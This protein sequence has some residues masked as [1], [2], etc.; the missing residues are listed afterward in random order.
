MIKNAT[1]KNTEFTPNLA[2]THPRK[3]FFAYISRTPSDIEKGQ[4]TPS[5][6]EKSPKQKL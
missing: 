5:D 1:S 3:R 4:K 6:I 2:K